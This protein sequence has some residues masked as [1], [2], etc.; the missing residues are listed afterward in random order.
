MQVREEEVRL[1]HLL[2]EAVRIRSERMERDEKNRKGRSIIMGMRISSAQEEKVPSIHLK[3]VLVPD[4][5]CEEIRLSDREV[6]ERAGGFEDGSRFKKATL[7]SM[8][9]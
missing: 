1:S 6:L 8:I 5:L 2:S 7:G 4:R 9:M 3:D